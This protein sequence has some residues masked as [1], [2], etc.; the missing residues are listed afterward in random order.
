[1]SSKTKHEPDDVCLQKCQPPIQVDT[2]GDLSKME[3]GA[4][5]VKGACL[6]VGRVKRCVRASRVK[7]RALQHHA[8]VSVVLTT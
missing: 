1:M 4:S 3:I 7:G 8:N 2:F 6:R 5:R